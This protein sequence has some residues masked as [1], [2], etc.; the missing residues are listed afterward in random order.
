MDSVKFLSSSTGHEVFNICNMSQE[1]IPLQGYFASPQYPD[2][3]NMAV[4]CSV[5][6]PTQPGDTVTLILKDLFIDNLNATGCLDYLMLEDKGNQQ[7][8]Y[9]E[10]MFDTDQPT[11]RILSLSGYLQLHFRT[12]GRSS[13]S[14]G[15][16]LQYT[17]E[18][19]L[20]SQTD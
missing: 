15:F 18:S 14:R 5:T 9:C 8:K 2:P 20:L 11:T 19:S 12:T 10:T 16:L 17:S 3:Y 4:E 6:P 13:V 7:Y 1:A